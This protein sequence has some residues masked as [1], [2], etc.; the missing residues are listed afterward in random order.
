MEKNIAENIISPYDF[1]QLFQ[2]KIATKIGTPIIINGSIIRQI[3]VIDSLPRVVD[4][5]R[6]KAVGYVGDTLFITPNDMMMLM[7]VGKTQ[8]VGCGDTF[9]LKTVTL[10]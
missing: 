4:G 3:I 7:H 10:R 6:N 9:T 2:N 1:F 8:P 5:K